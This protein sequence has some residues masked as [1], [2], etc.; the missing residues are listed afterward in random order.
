MGK[1]HREARKVSGGG[2][3]TSGGDPTIRTLAESACAFL[4]GGAK[5]RSPGAVHATC[6]AYLSSL[7]SGSRRRTYGGLRG[8]IRALRARAADAMRHGGAG[9]AGDGR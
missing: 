3:P 9:G 4:K 7:R 8:A 5:G 1:R 6:N 2:D